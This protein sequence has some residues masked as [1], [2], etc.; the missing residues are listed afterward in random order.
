MTRP[1][2]NALRRPMMSPILPPVSMNIAITRQYSVI[3]AWIVVTVV[4][5]SAT[6]ALIE[7]FIADWS[8]TITNWAM[9]NATSG[10]QLVFGGGPVCVSWDSPAVTVALLLGAEGLPDP[11]R[12]CGDVGATLPA[13][14][15]PPSQPR[16][17][18]TRCPIPKPPRRSALI[19]Q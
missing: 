9:A 11:R 1:T 12:A 13:T 18:G 5:K 14:Q 10:N 7:T 17:A 19:T 6:R 15:K 16:R 3:T 2:T 4:S 8:S